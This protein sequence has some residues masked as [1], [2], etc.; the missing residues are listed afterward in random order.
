MGTKYKVAKVLTLPL[1]KCVQDEPLP[2]MIL[3]PMFVGKEM[4]AAEGAKKKEPATLVNAMHLDTG[5]L[6][7]VIC[8]AVVKSVLTEFYPNDS[9]VGKCFL[10]TKHGKDEGKEYNRF[11]V[12]EIEAPDNMAALKAAASNQTIEV[13]AKDATEESTATDKNGKK[14]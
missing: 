14:K 10:L 11:D 4:K 9:Y 8:H 5:E 6:G 1:F 7:Q 13:G 3:D 12:V 2:I